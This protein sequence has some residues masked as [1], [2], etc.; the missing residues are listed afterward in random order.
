MKNRDTGLD[1][2]WSELA[3]VL[4]IPDVLEWAIGQSVRKSFA[5]WSAILTSAVSNHDMDL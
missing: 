1:R 4:G 3:T 5:A 2:S